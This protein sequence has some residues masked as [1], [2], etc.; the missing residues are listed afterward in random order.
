MRIINKVI[1][2]LNRKLLNFII[3]LFIYF[4]LLVHQFDNAQVAELNG[5]NMHL[6]H[7]THHACINLFGNPLDNNVFIYLFNF[8]LLQFQIFG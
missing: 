6:I 7:N 3:S 4:H 1:L 5:S 2:D 8:N